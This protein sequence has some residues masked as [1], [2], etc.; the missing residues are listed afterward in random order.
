MRRI[1]IHAA[2]TFGWL[3]GGLGGLY[4]VLLWL[5]APT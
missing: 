3:A 2:G 4:L 5:A 1:L